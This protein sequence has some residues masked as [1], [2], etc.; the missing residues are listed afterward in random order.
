MWIGV[1]FH[2]VAVGM[3]WCAQI[4]H[5]GH[6]PN[7]DPPSW[8][9]DRPYCK[10]AP[11][12]CAN[13][14]ETAMTTFCPVD[15]EAPG[16]PG[17]AEFNDYN[18][19]QCAID[20]LHYS[21]QKGDPFAVFLGLHFPHLSHRV[22]IWAVRKYMPG[23]SLTPNASG[24]IKPAT[25]RY[26]PK[27]MPDIAFTQEIDGKVNASTVIDNVM[28]TFPV[29]SP[30]DDSFPEWFDSNFR[31]GYRSA[32]TLSDYHIGLMLSALEASGHVND[33]IVVRENPRCPLV[34][35]SAL[36]GP[37]PFAPLERVAC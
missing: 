30:V 15:V 2:N 33:T 13:T 28:H 37:W 24:T 5:P 26:A 34:L 36:W 14:M 6:P 22:P 12:S 7:N 18:M 10:Q 32:I 23:A 3:S 20:N 16:G 31:L 21:I 17:D 35:T 25:N 29:P 1:Y 27:G 19:T 4:Y 11:K 8:S 9:T